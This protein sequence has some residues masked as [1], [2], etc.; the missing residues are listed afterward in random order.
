MIKEEEF[1][2]RLAEQP[3]P[4]WVREMQE[5]YRKTGTYR[6]ADLRRLLGDPTRSVD[7]TPRGSAAKHFLS[8]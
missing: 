7:M 4:A 3:V 2:R 1:R 8:R 6:P 5:H